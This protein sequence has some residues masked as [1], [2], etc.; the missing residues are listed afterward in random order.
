MKAAFL[1]A[2]ATTALAGLGATPAAA[3]GEGNE[4]IMMVQIP[5]GEDC[6]DAPDADTIVVCEEIENPYRIPG[7]L[8]QSR[9]PENNSWTERS[10]D[11]NE[12]GKFGPGSCTNIGGGSELGCSIQEIEEAVA[13]REVAPERRFSMQI[14]EARRER[15]E[16]IDGEA[17]RTQAR[18]EELERAYIERL[19][20]ERD[21][22][23][24][25]EESE[26]LPEIQVTDP[27]AIAEPP[28]PQ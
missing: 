7:Q 12:V 6:P 8:R 25:G 18:V 1:L 15:L 19:E 9:D 16:E 13:E 10:R 28:R 22:P 4:R 27:E 14:E 20:A 24:P 3:Q 5:A 21:A 17:A 26:A 2:A 23:L 11:F